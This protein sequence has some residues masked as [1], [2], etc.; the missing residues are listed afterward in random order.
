[1]RYLFQLSLILCSL[2]I[3]TACKNDA[4]E[5]EETMPEVA[6][7][8]VVEQIKQEPT[9]DTKAQSNSVMARIM[10]TK[11]CNLLAS[12]LVT[13]EL[14]D[15][16]L[17]SDGP[18]TVFAPESDAFDALDAEFVKGLP[19]QENRET[20][21]SILKGHVIEGE[22]DSASL[23]KQ[24]Q[25][26]SVTLNTMSGSELKVRKNGSDIVVIDEQGNSAK[27]GKSDI[28]A[29]NGVVHVIDKVLTAN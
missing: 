4:K 19:L 26:G 27:V 11:E 20:L 22:L 16:L 12:Y 24:L 2:M 23:S 15:T 6:T 14:A 7:D 5:Q 18:F 1:M 28:T 3:F 21:V 10:T 29:S 9:E 8:T 13:A 17:K 25:I